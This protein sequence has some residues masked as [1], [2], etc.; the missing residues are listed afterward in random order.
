MALENVQPGVASD[1][2]GLVV[3]VTAIADATDPKLAEVNAV[4][5]KKLTYGLTPDGFRHE[6]TVATITSGR[7]TLAQVL[8]IDGQVTDTLEVQYVYTNDDEVDVVRTTLT[9]GVDGFIVHRLGY[10]N[11]EPFAAG[12]KVDVIPVRASIQRRVAPTANTELTIIQKLNV[13]G[14]VERFVELAA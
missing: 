11:D 14:R 13:T 1:G 2:N 5:S 8:E 6:S 10:A 9:P 12:Q 7:Y 3:F 4:T